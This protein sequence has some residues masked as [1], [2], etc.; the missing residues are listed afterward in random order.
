MWDNYRQ[1][2]MGIMRMN[3]YKPYSLD[4]VKW[5]ASK[6]LFSVITTFSGG[7]G[8][9]IGYKLSG[10]NVLVATDYSNEAIKTYN[11]NFPDTKTECGNILDITRNEERS[12]KD[13]F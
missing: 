2:Q 6:N 3:T 11:T 10:G 4:R 12:V 8:S 1:G 7:G 9:S 5:N 13:W